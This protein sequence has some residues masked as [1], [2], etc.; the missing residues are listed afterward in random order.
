MPAV[1]LRKGLKVYLGSESTWDMVET[2]C[3]GV[4]WWASYP[5]GSLELFSWGILGKSVGHVPF[6]SSTW[7]G[8]GRHLGCLPPTFLC[9]WMVLLPES[10]SS[11]A[12]PA[13]TVLRANLEEENCRSRPLTVHWTQRMGIWAGPWRYL[14][15]SQLLFILLYNRGGS[16]G[17][18]SIF[19]MH[20]LIHW[21]LTSIASAQGIVSD[22]SVKTATMNFLGRKKI[23]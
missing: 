20:V 12:F 13:A 22:Q 5:P 14:V 1:D 17:G 16:E 8:G 7:G 11:V 6:S 2:E 18:V 3:K 23:N 15:P 9:H 4:C 19:L 10:M 21:K